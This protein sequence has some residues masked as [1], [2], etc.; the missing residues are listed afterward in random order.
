[1]ITVSLGEWVGQNQQDDFRMKQNKLHETSRFFN[2][3]IDSPIDAFGKPNFGV[4]NSAFKNVNMDAG[5]WPV[6]GK[7]FSGNI[8]NARLKEWQHFAVVWPGGMLGLAIVDA[9]YLVTSWVHLV[10]LSSTWFQSVPGEAA[11]KTRFEHRSMGPAIPLKIPFGRDSISR[12]SKELLLRLSRSFMPVYRTARSLWNEETFIE[13]DNYNI[14]I[15]NNLDKGGHFVNLKTGGKKN[16]PQ[17]E[18]E[19]KCIHDTARIEPLVV[20]LPVENKQLKSM[21]S[22]KVPL[23][24]EGEIKVGEKRISLDPGESFALLDIHK[25]HYPWKTWWNWATFAGREAGGGIVGV[26]LTKN[27][28]QYDETWNENALWV[29]GRIQRLSSAVFDFDPRNPLAPWK[30]KDKNGLVD[31]T[32]HP[33]GERTEDM[34]LGILRSSFHQ[35]FGVFSGEVVFEGK[36]LKIESLPGVCENHLAYW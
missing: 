34:N 16:S 11:V 31:L 2:A 9:K 29:D 32:F 35:P 12:G 5:S 28:N 25:A 4:Y 23:P 18:A 33:F 8:Y 21:Y 24:V 3:P 15:R 1:M 30:L 27:V 7:N 19:F 20:V 26:N 6:I 14:R 22:H 17:L 10:E 13:A 36:R